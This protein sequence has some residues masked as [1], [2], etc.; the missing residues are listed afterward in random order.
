MQ[1]ED[2]TVITATL[3]DLDGG[4]TGVTWQWAKDSNGDGNYTDIDDATSPTYKP[5][6]DD[7]SDNLR[8]TATYTDGF[9][10]DTAEGTSANSVQQRLTQNV[11]PEFKDADDDAL[12]SVDREVAEEHDVGK[13]ETRTWASPLW[14]WPTTTAL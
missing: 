14:P 5:V 4:E 7:V 10:E 2:G 6:G 11:A 8:V 1:P 13:R 3:E 9:G 12:T